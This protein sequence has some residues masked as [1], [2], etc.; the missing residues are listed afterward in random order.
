MITIAI[1]NTK[2]KKTL[3]ERKSTFNLQQK[4]VDGCKP[5]TLP[6]I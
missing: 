3:R 1:E 4:Q 2:K 5:Q 6:L